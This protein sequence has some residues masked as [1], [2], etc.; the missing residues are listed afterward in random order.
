MSEGCNPSSPPERARPPDIMI[1]QR[2]RGALQPAKG[3]VRAGIHRPVRAAGSEERENE[4]VV[5]AGAFGSCLA[6]ANAVAVGPP[7]DLPR[8]RFPQVGNA[9]GSGAGLALVSGGE[10]EMAQEIARGVRY[11]ELGAAPG[12]A[13]IFARATRLGRWGKIAKEE[14]VNPMNTRVASATK[15]VVIAFERPTVLIGERINPTG[16]KRLAAALRDGDLDP[17]RAAAK[18]QVAAGADVLDINVGATGVDEV[19]WLPAAVQAVAEV[20]DVPLCLD[21][22]NPRALEAALR[23][24]PGRPII[25]SVTGQEAVLAEILP[26]ARQFNAPVVGL[27][28]GDQGIPPD[29]DGRVALAHKIVERAVAFG[30][31]EEDV[32]ID[33]LTLALGANAQA[34]LVT[35]EAV[36]RVRDELGVNQTLGASNISHGLPNREPL[37]GAF[38]ALAIAGGVTCP[39]VDVAKA[40]LAVVSTD[41]LLG[42]DGYARRF[43]SVYRQYLAASST[44]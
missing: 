12:V 11:P 16:K 31:S 19:V 22:H 28:M 42:R 35:L 1:T 14:T 5:V 41:L 39:T 34:G 9:V 40:R 4:P 36:R 2:A 37:T 38:L 10:R 32:I 29:A 27:T 21:S 24:C 6:S 7:P 15:E 13:R 3:A 18:A 43:I 25:N 23:V 30:I 33:C 44:A 20:V 26:L 8:D 17:V